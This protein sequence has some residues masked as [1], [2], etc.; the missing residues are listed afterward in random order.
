MEFLVGTNTF[1]ARLEPK[2]VMKAFGKNVVPRAEAVQEGLFGGIKSAWTGICNFVHDTW[3]ACV[4]S[5]GDLWG[6][7]VK[8]MNV[9]SD[10]WKLVSDNLIRIWANTIDAFGTKFLLKGSLVA[11]EHSAVTLDKT[12]RR[13][14]EGKISYEKCQ[15][16]LAVKVKAQRLGVAVA[17]L[18]VETTGQTLGC[19]VEFRTVIGDKLSSGLFYAAHTS[20]VARQI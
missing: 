5:L 17:D 3:A 20:F 7:F 1:N 8:S 10:N 4:K 14:L 12:L 6:G 19:L 18:Q 2:G 11:D 9:I 16:I 13:C 15:R